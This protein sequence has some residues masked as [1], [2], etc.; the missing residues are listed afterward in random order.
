MPNYEFKRNRMSDDDE[1]K[2]FYYTDP[3]PFR[4]GEARNIKNALKN[5]KVKYVK[6]ITK[7]SRFELDIGRN[8]GRVTFKKNF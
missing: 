3:S 8:K 7:D 1:L 6:P 4:P 2:D 5:T